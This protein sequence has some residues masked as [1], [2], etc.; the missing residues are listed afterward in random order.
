MF[1][2]VHAYVMEFLK[3]AKVVRFRSHHNK[4][5]LA[6]DDE[7]S[8]WQ[9][10]DGT[11]KNARWTVEL[12]SQNSNTLRLKS[13]FG[14][15]LTAL[16]TPYLLGIKSKK[17]LQT[18]PRTLD[19]IVEWEP[20]SVAEGYKVKLKTANGQ[21][22]R[23]NGCSLP[24]WKDSISHDNPNW[25]STTKDW[26]L[27]NV[28]VVEIRL[29]DQQQEEQQERQRQREQTNINSDHNASSTG[30]DDDHDKKEPGSPLEIDLTSPKQNSPSYKKKN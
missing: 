5:L 24:P 2:S 16:S 26:I 14:K 25:R 15:Y 10:R 20:V 1:R 21:Y 3:Q 19:S 22:L 29:D 18:L 13:C 28:D 4:Y 11:V 12:I 6:D 9:N 23:A 8:V 17:V 27:W 7:V 30:G